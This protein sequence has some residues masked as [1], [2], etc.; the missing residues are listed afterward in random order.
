[1]WRPENTPS[2]L[3]IEASAHALQR[4]PD[5][6]RR[7]PCKGST[8]MAVYSYSDVFSLHQGHMDYTIH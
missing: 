3:Q 2:S 4:R 5:A 7:E 1:M 8:K 6:W